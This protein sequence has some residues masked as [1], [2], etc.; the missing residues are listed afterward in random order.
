MY[1]SINLTRESQFMREMDPA[2]LEGNAVYK[3][4]D[5]RKIREDGFANKNPF[6]LDQI[7][8]RLD[9]VEYILNKRLIRNEKI[10]PIFWKSHVRCEIPKW[11]L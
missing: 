10:F 1:G 2:L 8:K 5:I 6:D 9:A 11:N 3:K 7:N 4:R